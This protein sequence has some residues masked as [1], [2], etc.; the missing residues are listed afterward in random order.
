V[1]NRAVG[2]EG[3]GG[4]HADRF[5]HGHG[6][7]RLVHA[8]AA[9]PQD[10]RQAPAGDRHLLGVAVANVLEVVV[11]VEETRPHHRIAGVPVQRPPHLVDAGRRVHHVDQQLR[12][13]LADA[14][15]H[16]P[17]VAGE[18]VEDRK[19]IGGLGRVLV[20]LPRQHPIVNDTDGRREARVRPGRVAAVCPEPIEQPVDIGRLLVL[21]PD[22]EGNRGRE[23]LVDPQKGQQ[24]EAIHPL[25]LLQLPRQPQGEGRLAEEVLVPGV[26]LGDHPVELNLELGR[27]RREVAG[28]LQFIQ[29]GIDAAAN[30]LGHGFLLRD[31][32]RAAKCDDAKE[33]GGSRPQAPWAHGLPHIERVEPPSRTA[34]PPVSPEAPG[35]PCHAPAR[36][37]RP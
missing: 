34:G 10:V 8:D 5:P 9:V 15:E 21:G 32:R 12:R 25:D 6:E 18:V 26:G 4:G 22:E 13:D 29:D 7:V 19:G 2:A 37:R 11:N 33:S 3:V 28:L 24:L 1:R 30:L 35:R 16:P 27:R 23:V 17:L 31:R 20:D 36:A 14:E